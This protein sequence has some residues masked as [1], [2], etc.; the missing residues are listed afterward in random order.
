MASG[1]RPSHSHRCARG[2]KS[3]RIR[4]SISLIRLRSIRP[5]KME[6]DAALILS[7]PRGI[8]DRE[9]QV[10]LLRYFDDLAV[11]DI[12]ALLGCP[13]GTVTKQLSRALA[14]LRDR[15]KETS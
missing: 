7:A 4:S 14:R 9:Q 11:A 8:P 6:D 13:V 5:P 3:P 10:L 2:K 15:L 12:A 1:N